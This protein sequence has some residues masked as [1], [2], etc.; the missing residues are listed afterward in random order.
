MTGQH[1]VRLQFALAEP[2]LDSMT[3]RREVQEKI[4]AAEDW[5]NLLLENAALMDMRLHM[6][7]KPLTVFKKIPDLGSQLSFWFEN[8]PVSER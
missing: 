4:R 7:S 2:V 5:N 6:W 8:N 3:L 1:D